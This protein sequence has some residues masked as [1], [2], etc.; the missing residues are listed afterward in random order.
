[1][2][3]FRPVADGVFVGRHQPLD[4]NVTLVLGDE[5]ALVIDTLATD[6]QAE[7]LLVDVRALTPLPLTVLNT[8]FHFDHC[9][10][11]RVVAAGGRPVWAHHHTA[12]ELRDR[13]EVWRRR[14]IDDWSAAEPALADALTSVR[15]HIP[16]HLVRETATLDLGGR[17]VTLHHPGPGHTN[18]DLIAHVPDV[19]VMVAGDLVEEGAAPDFTDAYPLEWPAAL[20]ALLRLTTGSSTI[21]PGHGAIVDADFVVTQH[22]DLARFEWLIRDGHAA[23]ATIAEVATQA[24]FG[25]RAGRVGVA[26]GFAALDAHP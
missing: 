1:M 2:R 6:A 16:D 15:I 23:G 18:G 8:H 25:E 14:W 3:A 5:S 22:A 19:D 26:R 4:V 7:A 9:F 21:V 24:P 17:V 10:G 12:A 13:G 11:N 20:A